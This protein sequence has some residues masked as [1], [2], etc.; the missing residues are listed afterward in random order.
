MRAFLYAA[1]ESTFCNKKIAQTGIY[2][3]MVI[4]M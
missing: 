1:T 3:G 2:S 4:E